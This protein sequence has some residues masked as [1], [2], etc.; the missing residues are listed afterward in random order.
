MTRPIEGTRV[1]LT[2][3][4]DRLP[5]FQVEAGAT[6]T[7]TVNETDSLCVKMDTPIPGCEGWDNEIIWSNNDGDEWENPPLA[8]LLADDGGPVFKS[9]FY[10]KAKD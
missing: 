1:R 7:V 3:L 5:H 4:V 9:P 8:T 2:T 6:G 10:G